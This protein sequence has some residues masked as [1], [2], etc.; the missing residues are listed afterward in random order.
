MYLQHL[1]KQM[2]TYPCTDMHEWKYLSKAKNLCSSTHFDI[3]LSYGQFLSI[4][5]RFFFFFCFLKRVKHY[6]R[7]LSFKK[8]NFILRDYKLR[9]FI[10]IV[11]T[12]NT[13]F[14]YMLQPWLWSNLRK[15]L[16][17]S[18]QKYLKILEYKFS[19]SNINIIFY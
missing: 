2:H 13:K 1:N 12:L 3:N 14:F 19:L 18:L 8:S 10:V 16:I 5:P 11:S 9:S 4:I 17:N 15:G 6:L 7:V